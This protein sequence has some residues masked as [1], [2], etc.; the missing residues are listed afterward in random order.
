MNVSICRLAASKVLSQSPFIASNAKLNFKNIYFEKSISSFLITSYNL[1]ITNSKFKYFQNSI[2]LQNKKIKFKNAEFSFINSLFDILISP[3]KGGVV[4]L[5]GINLNM[6]YCMFQNLATNATCPCF[7]VSNSLLSIYSCCIKHCTGANLGDQS[8][9]NG[10][11]ADNM[12]SVSVS[13]MSLSV[14]SYLKESSDSAIGFSNAPGIVKFLNSSECFG[15]F[16]AAS[17]A[18]YNTKDFGSEFVIISNPME[19]DSL[20]IWDYSH[21]MSFFVTINTSK[22]TCCLFYA[23]TA[24]LTFEDSI[25]LGCGSK[26]MT[27]SG[28][29]AF[30]RCYCD[31]TTFDRQYYKNPIVFNN[32]I[33]YHY[34]FRKDFC[35]QTIL[36]KRCIT[37]CNILNNKLE[38]SYMFF[39]V[40]II[41]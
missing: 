21:T 24:T 10:F 12:Q 36:N 37:E 30:N 5:N 13:Q 32:E 34:V 16:G 29:V 20:E 11:H 14:V 26:L 22:T 35:E 7:F 15:T 23:H 18:C 33:E 19:C 6:S 27:T 3:N 28:I 41:I 17:F 1:S 39:L 8:L 38:Q 31:S 40:N 25:I 9:S 2:F 4:S